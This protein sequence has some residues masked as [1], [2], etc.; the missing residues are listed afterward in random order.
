MQGV[1]NFAQDRDVDFQATAEASPLGTFIRIT[2]RGGDEVVT[3][4]LWRQDARAF[5]H[6]ILR[7]LIHG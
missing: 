7:A 1:F 3:L 4:E 2:V 6:E 5:A